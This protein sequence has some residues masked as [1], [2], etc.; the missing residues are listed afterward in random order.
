[1]PVKD[2]LGRYARQQRRA[3]F[4]VGQ[5]V[6]LPRGPGL[7]EPEQEL[8]A[9]PRC[10]SAA[11]ARRRLLGAGVRPRRRLAGR[12]FPVVGAEGGGVEY[13]HGEPGD[14]GDQLAFRAE[15]VHV[16]DDEAVRT[17]P[18]PDVAQEPRRQRPVDLEGAVDVRQVEGLIEV[19]CQRGRRIEL[20]RVQEIDVQVGAE[21]LREADGDQL[22][23]AVGAGSYRLD[24]VVAG[25]EAEEPPGS[26]ARRN[27]FLAHHLLAQGADVDL[28]RDAARGVGDAS[29]RVSRPDGG[30][31]GLGELRC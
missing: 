23:S 26:A 22:L 31:A 25:A 29:R 17:R 6:H 13:A 11:G 9:S 27:G 5:D 8:H 28:A 21:G 14:R 2:P 16:G 1:M 18:A 3:A 10:Q 4:A 19:A 24:V 15:Q 20:R 7:E 12:P 30:P